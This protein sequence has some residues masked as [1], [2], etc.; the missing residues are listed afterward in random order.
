MP[1]WYPPPDVRFDH[2][3]AVAA[4]AEVQMMKQ[5]VVHALDIESP[6]YG[7]AQVHWRGRTRDDSEDAYTLHQWSLGV[8]LD[9]LDQLDTQLSDA[10]SDAIVEQWRRDRLQQQWA[11]ELAAERAAAARATADAA[12]L[13]AETVES[14]G[15]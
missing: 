13:E 6:A 7:A 8:A 14:G 10:M 2:S 15:N 5:T 3:A 4:L 9:R 11:D 12:A 1:G